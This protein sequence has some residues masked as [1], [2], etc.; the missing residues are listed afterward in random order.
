MNE[1]DDISERLLRTDI[2][3]L[4]GGKGAMQDI[5]TPSNTDLGMPKVEG[6]VSRPELLG[7]N[8]DEVLNHPPN[9]LMRWGTTLFF[10]VIALILL[11][12]WFVKYPDLV[13]APLQILPSKLPKNI[14][15]RSEGRIERLFVGNEQPVKKGEILAYIES[16]AD[17][18]DVLR[19][20]AVIDE[21][22]LKEG[23]IEDI[24]HTGIPLYFN[25]G[26]LQKSYQ[27]FQEAHTRSK[28][29][30]GT[31]TFN[32]KKGAISNEISSLRNL[33]SN[34]YEQLEIQEKDLQMTLEEAQSQQRLA[35]KGFVSSLEAKNAMSRYLNKK[36]SYEQ[37]KASLENNKISQNQK[38]YELLEMDK[39]IEEH[40]I[41]LIQTIYSFKSDIEAWKQKY[42][43]ISPVDGIVHFV[44][45]LQENQQ[46][47]AGQDLMM[48]APK[49]EGYF[50]EM[51]VGQYNFGKIKIGQEVIVKFESYPFQEFGTVIGKIDY[52]GNMPRDSSTLIKVT[53]RDGLITNSKKELPFKYGM[54]ANAEIVTEDMRLM[55]RFFYDIRKSLKR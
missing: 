49:S 2:M 15:S 5:I 39:T 31:G 45:T 50:G 51:W 19:L 35:D 54:K 6:N 27:T 38:K 18:N 7:S 26:E 55:E 48:V 3:V 23:N 30:L 34:T 28:S 12:T 42:L 53:F 11:V 29:A 9:W 32:K 20:E 41:N 25:L 43:A 24:Y 1:E 37:A 10:S 13:S 52:I 22:I 4:L 47:Q 44:S 36:Q 40:N 17:I 46:V 21:L 33:R 8:V 14:A 16:T